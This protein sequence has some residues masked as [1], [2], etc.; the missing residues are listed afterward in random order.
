MAKHCVVAL[1]FATQLFSSSGAAVL[2][3]RDALKTH[4]QTFLQSQAN[5]TQFSLWN[6][7]LGR[8]FQH[9]IEMK[10]APPTKANK[11]I[12]VILAMCCGFCGCDRC[13]MGQILLGCLKGGTFGGFFIWTIVDYVV[14]LVS[15]LQQTETLDWVGYHHVFEKNSIQGAM[16]VACFL[17]VMNII[18]NINQYKARQVQNEQQAAMVEAMMRMNGQTSSNQEP[19]PGMDIPVRHQ[20]LA[21]IPTVLTSNLRK[22]GLVTEKPTIPEIIALFDKLDKDGDGQLDREELQEGLAA[23]GASE[24]TVNDMIKEADTDGDGKIS[25]NEFLIN[26]TQKQDKK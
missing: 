3:N 18:Q 20:S 10:E 19:P 4:S 14:A 11:I 13:Y 22:A 6:N 12:W 8:R 15:A 1:L 23:M 21:Y 9:E 16:I 26:L 17:L 5:A 2:V 7:A 24:E 25:K